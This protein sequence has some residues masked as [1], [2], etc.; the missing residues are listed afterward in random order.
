V[1]AAL[2]TQLR[3]VRMDTDENRENLVTAFRNEL[4][5][6][7]RT[8]PPAIPTVVFD[9]VKEGIY[10]VRVVEV[11]PTGEEPSGREEESSEEESGE[12]ERGSNEGELTGDPD[13]G[14]EGGELG[15]QREEMKTRE[16]DGDFISRRQGKPDGRAPRD[17]SEAPP[18]PDLG[19]VWP[20]G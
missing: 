10:P 13:G 19:D 9:M 16:V 12:P 17:L 11:P 4:K 14:V 2:K 6:T 7:C 18:A 15:H 8:I 20:A 3:S 1:K 5:N